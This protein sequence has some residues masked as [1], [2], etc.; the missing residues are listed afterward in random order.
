M[1]LESKIDV[2][3]DQWLPVSDLMAGLMMV[4]LFI[5]ISVMT[6]AFKERDEARKQTEKMEEIANEYVV[7]HR[8][9]Y[10][11]LNQE[12]AA[13]FDSWDVDHDEDILTVTFNSPEVQFSDSSAVIPYKFESIL[14]EFFPRYVR[15]LEPYREYIQE[16]RLEGHTSSVWRSANTSASGYFSN[17]GLSQ[18]RTLSVL[19]Y[20]Y[21]LPDLTIQDRS[22]IKKKVAAVGHSFS[23]VVLNDEGVEDTSKSRRVTFRVVTNADREIRRILEDVR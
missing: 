5:S 21:S 1:D 18:L 15:V 6:S 19:E 20:V 16:V 4:F 13:D 23:H 9:I 8:A 17:M 12:F 2:D 3:D 22:W 7:K 11:S 10:E 14:R